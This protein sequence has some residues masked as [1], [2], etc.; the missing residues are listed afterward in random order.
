MEVRKKKIVVI[1]MVGMF[2]VPIVADSISLV[3]VAHPYALHMPVFP[4]DFSSIATQT[5]IVFYTYFKC[6]A[7]PDCIDMYYDESKYNKQINN[8]A[9]DV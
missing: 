6:G 3:K 7:E 8:M 9:V 5:P 2:F 4:A 1:V